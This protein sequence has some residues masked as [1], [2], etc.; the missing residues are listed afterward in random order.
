MT[1]ANFGA[2]RR[3]LHGAAVLA[4][5][6]SPAS[7][8]VVEKGRTFADLTATHPCSSAYTD[9]IARVTDCDA[10]D[11]I[12]DGE[13]AYQCWA[14]C[15]GTAPWEAVSI[16]AGSGGGVSGL[17]TA[18]GG[19]ALADNAIVR[20]DG[21]TGIQGSAVTLSDVG[22]AVGL[23]GITG[24]T[25]GTSTLTLDG[26]S[27]VAGTV[28]VGS[29]GTVT[30]PETASGTY[31]FTFDG[32]PTVGV[33]SYNSGNL[34]LGSAGSKYIVFR[35]GSTGL[36][37]FDDTGF[38]ML[39]GGQYKWETFGGTGDTGLGRSALGVV[40]CTNGGVG[41][42]CL[43]GGGTAIASATAL[44]LPTGRVFHVTGTTNISSITSTGFQNGVVITMIFD[45][46]LTVVDGSNMKLA[47]DFTTTADDTLTLTYDGTNWFENSRSIN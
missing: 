11:D 43:L 27:N 10:A 20:G 18:D 39:P 38:V 2:V 26:D 15:D 45:D 7:S 9:R 31:G 5:L 37:L 25:S 34:A 47:G 40:K 22:A 17:D 8:Q 36:A 28:T 23:T 35:T 42:R 44:P 46:A 4:L 24:G 12:G 19:T 33:Q 32:L 30:I 21:T 13:G 29:S 6:A 14:T 41:I 16:G 3:L 1:P